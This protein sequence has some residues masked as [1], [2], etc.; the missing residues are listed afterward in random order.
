MPVFAVLVPSVTSVAVTVQDPLVLS[1]TAK[2][3][4]PL[5]RVAS[6]GSVAVVSLLVMLMV[7][8]EGTTFQN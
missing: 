4:L 1:V 7:S 2:V 6:A 3:R 5:A 8:L